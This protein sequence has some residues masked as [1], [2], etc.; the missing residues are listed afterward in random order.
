MPFFIADIGEILLWLTRTLNTVLAALTTLPG[1]T[2]SGLH[3]SALQ[4]VLIYVLVLIVY[5]L[6]YRLQLMQNGMTKLR[7]H[8]AS[9]RKRN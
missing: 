1:A 2:V 8:S 9:H 3:P 6:L 4:V 7:S 5:T